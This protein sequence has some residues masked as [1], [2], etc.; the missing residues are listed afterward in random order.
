M[1][2]HFVK[3]RYCGFNSLS[4]MPEDGYHVNA[5]LPNGGI[6]YLGFDANSIGQHG[7]STG[8]FRQHGMTEMEWFLLK[9]YYKNI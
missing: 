1:K 4:G 9:R 7:A 3:D 5:I 2:L 8:I 6:V